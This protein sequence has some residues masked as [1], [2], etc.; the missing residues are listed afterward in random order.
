MDFRF[1]L[2]AK[3]QSFSQKNRG[4]SLN[5]PIAI[6]EWLNKD[7]KQTLVKYDNDIRKR[8][9]IKNIPEI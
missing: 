8:Q 6:G 9:I 7:Q 4:Q 2:Y 5:F 3:M 1:L